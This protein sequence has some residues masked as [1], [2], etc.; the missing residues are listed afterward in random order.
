[1]KPYFS[2]KAG[3]L[4]NDSAKNKTVLALSGADLPAAGVGKSDGFGGP[5]S[6]V[7][8][9]RLRNSEILSCLDTFLADLNGA[10]RDEIIGL[11]FSNL[12]LFSDVPTWTN[13]LEH[14]IEVE[15]SSPVKQHAYR[16]NPDKRARLK[17]QVEYM[18]AN[19]I[20]EPSSSA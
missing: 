20:A 19:G 17:S 18:L 16:V 1:M 9:G 7:V 15:D 2:G 3:C 10:Q 5:S 6:E 11:I 14:D 8:Q 4:T 12:E 13:V